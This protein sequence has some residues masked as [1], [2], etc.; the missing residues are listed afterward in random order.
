MSGIFLLLD[1]DQTGTG[2][3]FLRKAQDLGLRPILL[4]RKP[5]NFPWL[6]EFEHLK[7]PSL[8]ERLVLEVVDR[9]GRNNVKGVWSVRDKYV[10]LA[11]RVSSAIGKRGA[12][13][14]PVKTCCDK[15][16]T[17]QNLAEAGLNNVEFALAWS[18]NEAARVTRALGGRSVVK[19]RSLTGSVG[20]RLCHDPDEARLYFDLLVERQ[21]D[22]VRS[23]LLIEEVIDGPQFSVQIFDGQ[24]IGVTRQDVGPAPTFIT[25]GLDF[26]WLGDMEVHAEIV[27]HAERAVAVLG[28][29]WGPASIDFRYDSY[30]R[31]LEVNPRL[32]GDMI[33]ENIR[34]ATGTDVVEATIR[35]ACGMPYDLTPRHGRGS[36]TRW[37]LRPDQPISDLLG[38]EEAESVAG[39]VH[40]SLFPGSYKRKG[41]ATDYRDRL[42]FVISEA[43]S[44]EKAAEIAD[45]GLRRLEVVPMS[46]AET[47]S[48]LSA[49][50][51]E[52]PAYFW[53]GT[54][55]A[56]E[57][58]K[59]A[60]R[61][62]TR[63]GALKAED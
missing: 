45:A 20:V 62:L 59:V 46:V 3:L 32:A 49:A 61:R 39:V 2:I 26:P 21:P 25:V 15:F 14:E 19:P 58:W 51:N 6:L 33:P 16:K 36:A 12:D 41:L 35:F 48:K 24:A 53:D 5:D 63:T 30:P 55:K 27:S 22:L 60:A 54:I 50:A 10:E 17:R 52:S 7:L 42:A 47:R 40:V 11:A 44:T 28:H 23:G 18:G 37:L 43:E 56:I 34:L 29:K 9:F 13:P 4:S 1:S 57:T 8:D 31:I 38:R